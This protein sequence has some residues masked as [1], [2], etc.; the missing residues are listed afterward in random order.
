MKRILV[1]N[2]N[3]VGDVIFSTP[4]FKALKRAYP[5]ASITCLVVPRVREILEC[6]PCV[7][8]IIVYDEKGKHRNLFNKIKL[9]IELAR[10]RFDVAFLLHRSLTRALLVFL[11]GIPRRVGYDTKKRGFLLTHKVEVPD[12]DLHRADYYLNIIESFGVKVCDRSSELVVPPQAQREMEQILRKQGISDRDYL[13]VAHVG[14]NWALKLW[15]SQNFALLIRRLIHDGRAKVIIPGSSKELPLAEEIVRISGGEA[16]VLAGE[17]N[18]K[19]LIALMRRADMVI[20]ADSGP[21]HM[22]NSVGT[23]S[24]GLFGPTRPEITGPRGKGQYVVIQK[25]IGCNTNPCYL[26]QCPDNVCM[27]AITVED[28]IQEFEKIRN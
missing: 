14:G 27:R 2:V 18:L 7:D 17:T 12:G 8:Q 3:W 5:Q 4:V 10:G 16:L 9:I 25:D 22:A 21:L 1:V 26:L 15:P 24:I 19:Q 6:S 23:K 13:V 20:S 11:A 28:V